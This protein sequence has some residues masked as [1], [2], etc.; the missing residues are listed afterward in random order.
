MG[1]GSSPLYLLSILQVNSSVLCSWLS[2]APCLTALARVSPVASEPGRA[3]PL[4]DNQNAA[5]GEL[6]LLASA[7]ASVRI[8]SHAL[9]IG[10]VD[11]L[12]TPPHPVEGARI[13][14]AEQFG[15]GGGGNAVG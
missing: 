10:I 13:G 7:L 4:R 2:P 6:P 15:R 9:G 11:A 3:T 8:R 5:T 14:K 1:R 12:Q